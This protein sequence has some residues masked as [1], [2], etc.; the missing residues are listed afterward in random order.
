M[1]FDIR[2]SLLVSVAGVLLAL[3][4]TH[5]A[6][7]TK[8]EVQKLLASDGASFDYFGVSVAV[9]GDT[10]VIG[11]HLD[12]SENNDNGSAYVFIRS[13]T[14]W[15]EQAK[16]T[17]SDGAYHDFFGYS[18]AVDGDMAVI[19]A[20]GDDDN[21]QWTGSAYVFTRTAGTWTE[22]AKLTASDA[23]AGDQ[24]GYSV[25]V[26]GDTAV[27]GT[28]SDDNG[29]ASGSAYVFI[30][31]GTAWT[32]QAKLTASDAAEGD[33]F[34]ISVAVDGDM[35]VI[36]SP[37]DDRDGY[38]T[39]GAAYVFVRDGSGAWT[40]QAKLTAST[41][42]GSQFGTSVA[43]DVDMAVIG[44][45]YARGSA[46]GSG[47]A[48][49][50]IRSG[51]SWTEQGKLTASDGAYAD[52]FGKSVAVDGDMAVIGAQYDDD[53]GS[54][55][56]SA[57]V[58]NVID[59]VGPIVS[60]V[61]ATPNPVAKNTG[62]TLTATVSDS[63]TGG[64]NIASAS[65]RIDGGSATPMSADDGLFDSD[66]EVVTASMPFAEAG[67]HTLCVSGTDS[68]GN[69]GERQCLL[70]AVY[71]PEAG[72]VSGAGWIDSPEGAFA[73]D[74][75]LT[76]KA[77]FGFVSRYQKGKQTPTG[78]TEFQFQAGDLNFHSYSY[79]WLV[80]ASHRAQ[81]KGTGTINGTGNYGFMLFA[82]DESL[83]PSTDC[84]LFRIK[85][86]DKDHGDA[87]VYDSQL[88]NA[89]DAEPTTQIGGGSIVVHTKGKK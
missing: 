82:I 67:V 7:L 84:D 61:T 44:A 48:Y 77:N 74:P 71:D 6:A 18:V 43:V 88:G 17:A 35:A 78:T 22:Q 52:Q 53:N 87:V 2:N 25:A 50:F 66:T 5:A 8:T 81:Y 49:V 12:D 26:D 51:A 58:F 75:T 59:F 86:W 62:I 21:G 29:E 83:T 65:Y 23:A 64:Y 31:S 13:G 10:A 9:D 47:S 68:A 40:E 55:S 60:D 24:F 32:E 4:S 85:I 14:A 28:E 41:A 56:G 89:E 20:I 27:I 45:R 80:I 1:K 39:E 70:L 19:G 16:L 30:R 34:G 11:S 69:T 15:T 63:T 38:Y 76:G 3:F 73:A 72:F 33:H 36:G 46:P 57:Y 79:E 42:S 37:Y 54:D